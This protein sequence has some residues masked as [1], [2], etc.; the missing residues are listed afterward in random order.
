MKKEKRQPSLINGKRVIIVLSCLVL[1]A[2]IN[3]KIPHAIVDY[4]VDD[5]ATS[6]IQAPHDIV[7]EG[8]LSK[9]AAESVG[10]HPILTRVAAYDHDVGKL[11]KPHYCIENRANLED[12][13]GGGCLRK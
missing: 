5:T 7:V 12:V 6:L 11:K 13:H 2:I 3:V 1:A 4:R 9:A 8:S 10:A